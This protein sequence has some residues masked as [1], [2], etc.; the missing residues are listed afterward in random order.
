MDRKKRREVNG[1]FISLHTAREMMSVKLAPSCERN[2]MKAL[3]DETVQHIEQLEWSENPTP[4][5]MSIR[6][7]STSK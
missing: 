2:T 7:L 4:K 3:L 5:C 6:F 1:V